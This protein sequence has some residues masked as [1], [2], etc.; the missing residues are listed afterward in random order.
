M[1]DLNGC[2]YIA[3][4]FTSNTNDRRAWIFISLCISLATWKQKKSKEK[5]MIRELFLDEIKFDGGLFFVLL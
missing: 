5:K 2:V 1:Y 3:K 4:V